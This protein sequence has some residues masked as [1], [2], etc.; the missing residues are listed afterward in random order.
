M[1]DFPP[2]P[3]PCIILTHGLLDSRQAKT[4][5]GILRG[6]QRFRAVAVIDYRFAGRDAGEVMGGRAIGVGV[7]ASVAD[8]FSS[9]PKERPLYCLVGVAL[10]G[11]RLPDAFREQLLEAL[12][13]G[14]S[15]VNGLH[16]FLSD[17]PVFAA[18]AAVRGLQLIDVRKPRLRHALRFWTGDIYTVKAPII[19]VLGL[20]CAIGKRTTARWLLDACQ[21][22]GVYAE[23][24]YT[25]QTGWMQGVRYGFIFDSTLNDFISGELEGAIMAC[26]NDCKPDLIVIEGQSGLRNPSGPAGSEIILSGNARGIILQYAPTRSYY[27]GTRIPLPSIESEIALIRMYGA[28]VLAVTISEEGL[29]DEQAQAVQAALAQRT[30]LP[31]FRPLAANTQ[32]DSA[33]VAVVLRRWM[34]QQFLQ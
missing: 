11:G 10:A 27:E 14:L 12:N 33:A 15:L 25:G 13:H 9:S 17:D 5:H 1:Q 3:E 24:I 32:K 30:G 22:A 7:W 34:E 6:S 23:M 28:E 18:R 8:Y 2:M 29:D 20:D 26:A 16:T 19:A 4:C 31:V 21:K